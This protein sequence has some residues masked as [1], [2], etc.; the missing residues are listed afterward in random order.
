MRILTEPKN[1]LCKQYIRLL[2]FDGVRLTFEP[3]ALEAIAKEARSR[4]I[5]ARG[6]RAVMERLMTQ[7]MYDIPSE[8]NVEE[9]II[10]KDCV[11]NGA[12]PRLVYKKSA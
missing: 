4:E 12:K 8:Q 5:G 7:V 6:L 11:E 1:A 10:T 9:V 2:E 3:A